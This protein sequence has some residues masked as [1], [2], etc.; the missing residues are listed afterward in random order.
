MFTVTVFHAS[1]WK[2]LH[3]SH[4]R[5]GRHKLA[6]A[7]V[8]WGY[9]VRLAEKYVVVRGGRSILMKVFHYTWYD[10]ACWTGEVFG[11]PAASEQQRPTAGQRSRCAAESG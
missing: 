5:A 10:G 11:T 3:N 8:F 7:S 6:K 1:Q 9:T 2:C 4:A